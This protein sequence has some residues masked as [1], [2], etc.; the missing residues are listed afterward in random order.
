[1]NVF[2]AGSPSSTATA[3]NSSVATDTIE[4]TLTVSQSGLS[5]DASTGQY[6]YVWKTEK[7]W[8]GGCRTLIVR[9]ADGTVMY[10]YFR[11]TK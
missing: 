6:T 2:A 8:A 3:C 4:E 5:Y 9:F 1:L 11:F 7:S 10:A